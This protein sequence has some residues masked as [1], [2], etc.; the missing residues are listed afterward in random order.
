MYS[1]RFT[2]FSASAK[3][4]M[5]SLKRAFTRGFLE[6]AP[7]WTQGTIHALWAL[8]SMIVPAKSKTLFLLVSLAIAYAPTAK[9]TFGLCRLI[10]SSSRL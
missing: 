6:T 3:T 1:K 4:Y 8:S 10:S 7:G 2:S 9:I 5:Q